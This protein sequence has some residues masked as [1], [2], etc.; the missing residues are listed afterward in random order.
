MPYRS[1]K[2]RKFFHTE[3]AKKLGIKPTTV[4][5]FDKASKGMDLPEYKENKFKNLKLKLRK[6]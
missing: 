4:K 6:G 5:E 1:E 2:Q 3:T